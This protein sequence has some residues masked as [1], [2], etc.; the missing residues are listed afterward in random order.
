MIQGV[1]AQGET[2]PP[3]IIVSSKYYLSSWYQDSSLPYDWV[4][5]MSSNGWTINETS[6][7][8][9]QHFNKYTTLKRDAD[10]WMLIIDSHKSHVLAEFD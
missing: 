4:I 5:A 8:W 9:I 6:L 10:Y 1:N 7:E 2:V 3:F